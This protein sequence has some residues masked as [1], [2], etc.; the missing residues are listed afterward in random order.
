MNRKKKV[1]GPILWLCYL[2]AFFK[3]WLKDVTFSNKSV[4]DM[5]SCFSVSF[6]LHLV[7]IPYQSSELKHDMAEDNESEEEGRWTYSLSLL[8]NSIFQK[9]V[10]GRGL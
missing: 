10:E 8:F 1:V 3:S 4:A 2:I 6:I 7:A 5:C 9:L